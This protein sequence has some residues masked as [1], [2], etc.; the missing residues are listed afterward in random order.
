MLAI[1]AGGDEQR[2]T[3]MMARFLTDQ[4][5]LYYV[6]LMACT[7]GTGSVGF[8]ATAWGYI[9]AIGHNEFSVG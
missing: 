1:T 7:D 2:R 5:W 4:P 8:T 3:T 6:I 9:M